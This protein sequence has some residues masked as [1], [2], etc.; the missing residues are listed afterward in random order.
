MFILSLGPELMTP[1]SQVTCSSTEPAR[2]PCHE[3][4]KFSSC[5]SSSD[6]SKGCSS[7]CRALQSRNNYL[8]G[9]H[10]LPALLPAPPSQ[11]FRLSR[12]GRRYA[13]K[14]DLPVSVR[15]AAQ[16]PRLCCAHSGLSPCFLSWPDSL[17]HLPALSREEPRHVLV[18]GSLHLPLLSLRC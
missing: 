7:V 17:S 9:A 1:R 13:L 11:A 10:S 3:S 2:C 14:T 16:L 18:S 12:G 8:A 15:T 5:Q 4:L 6:L